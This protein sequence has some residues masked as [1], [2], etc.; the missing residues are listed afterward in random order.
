MLEYS[1]LII[2]LVALELFL[3]NLANS[4]FTRIYYHLPS[5]GYLNNYK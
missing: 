3:D 1:I 5:I 2:N 4:N